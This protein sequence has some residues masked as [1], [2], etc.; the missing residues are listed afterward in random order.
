MEMQ[1]GPETTARWEYLSDPS[2]YGLWRVRRISERQTDFGFH[3]VTEGEAQALV[4]LLE[5]SNVE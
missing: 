2:V 3:L 5:D 4:E 1:K